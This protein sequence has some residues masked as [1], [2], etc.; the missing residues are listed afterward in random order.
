MDSDG[1]NVP[2]LCLCIALSLRIACEAK[3]IVWVTNSKE[4][5]PWGKK[6]C[7]EAENARLGDCFL[8]RILVLLCSVYACTCVTSPRVTEKARPLLRQ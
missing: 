5:A 4:N 3:R 6:H 7:L 1:S 8:L 2:C